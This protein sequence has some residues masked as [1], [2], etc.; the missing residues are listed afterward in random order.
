M[1]IFKII[2][3]FNLLSC[4]GS[5]TRVIVEYIP[6]DKEVENYIKINK[7]IT[8]INEDPLIHPELERDLEMELEI[9]EDMRSQSEKDFFS[10]LGERIKIDY[11]YS[12][13]LKN[14]RITSHF[15]IRNHPIKGVN[16]KHN[17]VDLTS[18]NKNI[19]SIKEGKVIYSRYSKT[20]GNIIAIRHPENI[21]SIYAHNKENY[22]K[23]GQYVKRNQIIG[24]IGN[25]GSVTGTHLH[26]EI[27]K[28][29]SYLNPIDFFK[30]KI[31]N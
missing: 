27:R 31:I 4:S 28:G 7:E 2:I 12:Y 22:V 24:I 1:K 8:Q 29:S 30:N 6:F 21:I 11:V 15:G 26:F 13:P 10:N 16:Q 5:P 3:F 19:F 17:G 25:T 23:K 14:F 18:K 20:Y 9:E